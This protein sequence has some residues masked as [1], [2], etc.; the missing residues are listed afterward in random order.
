MSNIIELR[1]TEKK[2]HYRLLI[3]GTDVTGVQEKG[4]FRHILEVVDKGIDS[5]Q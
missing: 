1:K 5:G 4:I 3:N 2:D